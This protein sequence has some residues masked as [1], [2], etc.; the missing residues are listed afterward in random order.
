MI[1]ESNT[2]GEITSARIILITQLFRNFLRPCHRCL[3]ILFATVHPP[4]KSGGGLVFTDGLDDP[5]QLRHEAFWDRERSVSLDFTSLKQ[6]KVSCGGIWQ[7]GGLADFLHVSTRQF[8]SW[9]EAAVWTGSQIVLVVPA[10]KHWPQEFYAYQSENIAGRNNH[11]E[12]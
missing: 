10:P 11:L 8:K 2:Q 7:I 5:L 9:T 3:D 6:K 1:L 4:L 12:M